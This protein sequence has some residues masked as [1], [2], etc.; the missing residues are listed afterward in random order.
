MC[1]HLL[2]ELSIAVVMSC[3]VVQDR[4]TIWRRRRNSWSPFCRRLTIRSVRAPSRNSFRRVPT[5]C[6]CSPRCIGS[7][8]RRSWRRQFPPTFPGKC[9]QHSRHLQRAALEINGILLR[10]IC[11]KW[12][13]IMFVA[14]WWYSNELICFLHSTDFKMPLWLA[15]LQLTM[16]TV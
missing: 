12:L 11:I 8:W 9:L 15:S 2:F 13:V 4:R 3:V 14:V 5:Y 7:Q 16:C 10:C 6:R 1:S